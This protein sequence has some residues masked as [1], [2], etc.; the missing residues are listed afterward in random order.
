MVQCH[1]KHPPIHISACLS[2][3]CD[4]VVRFYGLVH[5]E[6]PMDEAL[7]PS[8]NSYTSAENTVTKDGILHYKAG[9]SYLGKEQWKTCF[10][11]LRWVPRPWVEAGVG[12]GSLEKTLDPFDVAANSCCPGAAWEE[13]RA[14]LSTWEAEIKPPIVAAASRN[15]TPWGC[16]CRGLGRSGC[17]TSRA[18]LPPVTIFHLPK[19]QQWDLVPVPRPHRRHAFAL[20]QHGVSSWW[21]VVPRLGRAPQDLGSVAPWDVQGGALGQRVI[22][23]MLQGVCMSG[24]G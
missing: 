18:E 19:W 20:H 16:V 23:A 5:W 9:T 11:V 3:A 17:G 1:T 6:D 10:V 4:V 13:E 22:Q 2:Q 15:T 12:W 21:V 24:A 14:H 7:G 8:A